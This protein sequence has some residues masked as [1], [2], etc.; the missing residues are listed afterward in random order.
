MRR[1]PLLGSALDLTADQDRSFNFMDQVKAEMELT[2]RTIGERVVPF[3]FAE[4]TFRK[5]LHLG[6]RYGKII[7][8][9]VLLMRP[10][11]VNRRGKYLSEKQ[12]SVEE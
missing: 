6:F 4:K 3:K 9:D 1:Q 12:R 10:Q 8:R 11:I 2:K 7:T 5:I